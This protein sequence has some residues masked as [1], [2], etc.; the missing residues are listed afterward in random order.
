MGPRA[1]YSTG[2][3][4]PAL[5]AEHTA[6]RGSTPLYTALY[7]NA[8][9]IVSRVGY[10]SLRLPAPPPR[11]VLLL[12]TLPHTCRSVHTVGAVSVLQW[13]VG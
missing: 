2:L 5:S 12:Q 9:R 13:N 6:Q 11:P 7:S 4:W 1:R 8:Q 3:H 10:E